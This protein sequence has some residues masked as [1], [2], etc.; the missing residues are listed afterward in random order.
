MMN[1]IDNTIDAI[2][3]MNNDC[4]ADF[5]AI[6]LFF[7]PMNLE[8]LLVAP[9]PSPTLAPFSTMK[10]G[11]TN[12]IPAIAVGPSPA[13]HIPSTIL[14]NAVKI[15]DIIMGIANF[16]TAFSGSPLINSTFLLAI[17]SLFFYYLFTFSSYLYQ[18]VFCIVI[19]LVNSDLLFPFIQ[20]FF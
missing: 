9:F 13:T 2:R 14:Y 6:S 11:V 10:M 19:Q 1:T 4:V 5:V 18:L 3:K 17:L 16:L 7:A 15:I 20:L 12:P 8:M